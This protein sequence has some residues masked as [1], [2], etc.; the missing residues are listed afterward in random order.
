VAIWINGRQVATFKGDPPKGP[1]Y[2]GLLAAS[3]PGKTGDTWSITDFKVSVP[4]ALRDDGDGT[5]PS[6]RS[7]RS[8]NR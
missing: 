6:S 4:R 3:A 8:R 2:V 5:P 7:R 1:R